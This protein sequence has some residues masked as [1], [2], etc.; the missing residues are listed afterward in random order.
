MIRYL[1][2]SISRLKVFR[3][4]VLCCVCPA[5]PVCPR[6]CRGGRPHEA[7]GG[8]PQAGEGGVGWKYSAIIII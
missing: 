8:D 5:G 1:N 7:P 6:Q 2:I 4:A 3:S